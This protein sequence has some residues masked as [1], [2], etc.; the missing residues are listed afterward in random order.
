MQAC[1]VPPW[2]RKRVVHAQYELC[3]TH[4]HSCLQY[5]YPV[6]KTL[7]GYPLAATA[8]HKPQPAI[9]IAHIDQAHRQTVRYPGIRRRNR[10]CHAHCSRVRRAC[11]REVR[12]LLSRSCRFG[13]AMSAPPPMM[14]R[15]RLLP[16]RLWAREDVLSHTHPAQAQSH[17]AP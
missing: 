4:N 16:P 15:D 17:T 2:F 13:C 14:M 5:P 7:T 1:R 6:L 12:L 9:C 10:T 11:V 3:M 8:S